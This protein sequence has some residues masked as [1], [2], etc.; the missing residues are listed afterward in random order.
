MTPVRAS[1][2]TPSTAARTCSRPTPRRS[3]ASSRCARST[4]YAPDA[5]DVRRGDRHRGDLAPKV[6]ERVR[7]KLAPRAVEDFRIDFEDGYGNRPDEEED[8]HAVAAAQQV[9]AGM[10]RRHA[11]A[12]HRH[13]HQAA[14]RASSR[15]ARCARSTCSSPSCST[16][17]NGTLPRELRRHAAED[18]SR[19]RRRGARRRVRGPRGSP[20]PRRRRAQA[21]RSWSRRT[22]SIFDPQGRSIL[23]RLHRAAAGR[24]HRRALRNLRLHRELR[25]HRRAPAACATRRATSP[26]T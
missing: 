16:R 23:P 17:P 3:S 8:G 13:P 19:D 26:S 5:G 4:T 7:E 1:R 18:H 20:R 6:Y 9:A 2:C 22:Q 12:V 25:H 21:S 24:L 11:A 15:R 14:H 10:R